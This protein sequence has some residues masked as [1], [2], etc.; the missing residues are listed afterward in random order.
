MDMAPFT[1]K[2]RPFYVSILFPTTSS[3]CA[4]PLRERRGESRRRDMAEK[5]IEKAERREDLLVRN[6]QDMD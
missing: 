4:L 5:H 6:G 1:E 3:L 2:G